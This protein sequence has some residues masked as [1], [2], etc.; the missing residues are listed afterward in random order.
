MK[1]IIKAKVCNGGDFESDSPEIAIVDLE[2]RQIEDILSK[3]NKAQREAIED[4]SFYKLEYFDYSPTFFS[5]TNL[6]EE[7]SELVEECEPVIVDV[8]PTGKRVR[9]DCVALNIKPEEIFWSAYTKHSN[10][11]V[12]TEE[13]SVD[14]LRSLKEEA[15]A[16]ES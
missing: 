11:R 4:T 8:E 6:D 16:S 12:E 10:T 5:D 7:K 9:V 3:C 14:F 1:V 13:L 2:T 15:L